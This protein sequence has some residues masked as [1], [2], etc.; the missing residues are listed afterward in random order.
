MGR[1]VAASGDSTASRESLMGM[2]THFLTRS[3]FSKEEVRRREL[4]PPDVFASASAPAL[5]L[6]LVLVL[7]T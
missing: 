4:V 1:P 3:G 7:V 2:G 5:V 6:V